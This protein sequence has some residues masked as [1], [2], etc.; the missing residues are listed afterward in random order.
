M[1]PKRGR[2]FRNGSGENAPRLVYAKTIAAALRADPLLQNQAA[3]KVQRWTG[4]G[5]RTVKNWF[6]GVSGPRGE[7]LLQLAYYSDSVFESVL[8]LAER[9][10]AI[11]GTKLRRVFEEMAKTLGTMKGIVDDDELPLRNGKKVAKRP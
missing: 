11:A 1:L 4:A 8:M 10:N 6:D 2:I 5:E 3:K 7:H 9:D